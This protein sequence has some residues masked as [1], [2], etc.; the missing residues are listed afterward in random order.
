MANTTKLVLKLGTTAGTKTW[1]FN[2]AKSNATTQN[3]KA[4]ADA[5]IANGSIYRYPPLTKESA[6]LVVATTTDIDISD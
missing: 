2:Y 3:I 6:Q 4:L 1:S 5:M